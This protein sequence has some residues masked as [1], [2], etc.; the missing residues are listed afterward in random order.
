MVRDTGFPGADAGD[1]FSR[2]RRRAEYARLIAWLRRE[3]EDVNAVLPFDAVVR[4]LGRVGERRLGLQS[5]DVASIVG[6][7][8]RTEDFDRRFRPTSARLRQRWE[9]LATA[10][11]RGEA[12]PP[13]TVYRIGTMHFVVDGHHRVSIA[14]AR[15]DATIDAYVTE[16]VTRISPEGV[17]QHSDLMRKDHYR[18]FLSRVPLTGSRRDAVTVRDPWDYAELAECIEAW[19]F[20]LMQERGEFLTRDVVAQ[21]WFD[22]EFV[23]VVDMV[24]AA[25]MLRNRTDAEAYLWLAGERYRLVRRH[26][27]NEEIIE[28]LRRRAPR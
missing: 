3:P 10:R 23:P 8:D 11:R 28:R 26:V 25:G 18:M 14:Y 4:A 12:V 13:I 27:W 22:E 9:K 16:I 7:V 6:S 5:I 17:T 2:Q 19:G 1:D 15:G 21:R 24:R 20:R